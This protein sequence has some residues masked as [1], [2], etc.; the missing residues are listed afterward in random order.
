MSTASGPR[1]CGLE[2]L[3][4]A[5]VERAALAERA[6][7]SRELHDGLAQDLWFAKLKV[8]RLAS[9][10][11]LGP[12]ARVLC[13]ELAGA[14]DSG[15]AEARQAVMALRVVGDPETSFGELVERYVDDFA[16]RFGLR[17]EFEARVVVPRLETRVEAEL[18]R[19]VQEALSNVH[20][21]ADATV[22]EVAIDRDAA[23]L[24]LSI[25]DN[26]R[27]FDPRAIGDGGFGL[28]SMRERA[29]LVSGHLEIRSRERDGT[30]VSV[31]VP[32]IGSAREGVSGL[33]PVSP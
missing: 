13:G 19:I 8:G 7:L 2:R 14:I 26:G 32:L 28:A 16:D 21:H 24:V 5:D 1:I 20:R 3:R 17:A 31:R 15:L 12:E 25:R 27:G 18:L 30:T 33:E 6:R 9:L 22:V 23:G 4:D 11:G 10:A 29:T